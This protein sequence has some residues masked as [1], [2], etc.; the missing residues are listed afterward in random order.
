MFNTFFK[1]NVD[2]LLKQMESAPAEAINKVGDDTELLNREELIATVMDD[3]KLPHEEAERI[4][5][6]IQMEEFDRIAKKL[7]DEGFIEI[8]SYDGDGN[9]VYSV[10]GDAKKFLGGS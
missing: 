6:E 5:T 2:D 3:Y 9:P 7:L 10:V 4:V 1:G 8:E